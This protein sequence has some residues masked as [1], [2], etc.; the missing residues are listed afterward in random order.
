[1][2]ATLDRMDLDPA[3]DEAA[4]GDDLDAGL[5][6][7]L[8]PGDDGERPVQ[9]LVVA[10]V[11]ALS[12]L[13]G[14]WMVTRAFRGGLV[15]VATGGL[16]VLLGAGLIGLSYRLRRPS[17][18][19]YLVLPAA[20]VVGGAL[21]TASAHG[22]SLPSLVADTVRGG[23][24]SQPPV[25]F[26][27]G[28]MFIAVVLFAFV[29]ASAAALGIAL[30]RPRLAVIA[31]LPV[32]IGGALIQPK[33]SE[34]LASAVAMVLVVASLALAYGVDLARKGVAG[35]GFEA[36]RLMRGA[37]LLALVVGVAFVLAQTNLLF[38]ATDRPQVIPPHKP[39]APPPLTDRVLFTV[40][41]DRPGPW[42][43]GVLDVYQDN[44]FL[45]PS[46]DQS[47]LVK[48]P[49][50]GRVVSTSRPTYTATF[51][52]AELR[53][54]SLPGVS[55]PVAIQTKT[56]HIEYDPRTQV[57]KQA[58]RALTSGSSYTIVAA[59]P[60]GGRELA[61]APPAPPAIA[62][63]F[64]AA[65]PAPAEVTAILSS[66]AGSNGFDRLQA[67]RQ[68]LYGKV[69]AAGAGKPV[70][71]PPQKVVQMLGGGEATP[72]EIVAGEVLLARWAG[73]PARIGYGFYGGQ[74]AAGGAREFH[75]RDGAA[76]LEAYFEGYGWVPIVGTPPKA[77]ASLSNSQKNPD[78]KI[79]PTDELGLVVF[80]P[81][82]GTSIRQLFELVR[83][84][85]SV[86]L[87]IGLLLVLM[88][89]GYPA[90]LKALRSSRRR[91]WARARGAGARIAVAYA[92]FRDRAN[93][94]NIGNPRSSPLRFLAPLADDEEHLELAWLV[95]RSLWGD[96]TRDLRLE[97]VEAAEDMARSVRARMT[98]AQT[99]I[100]RVLAA[101]ARTSLR[102]PWSDEIPNLWATSR[103]S[104][105]VR[106]RRPWPLRPPAGVAVPGAAVLVAVALIAVLTPGRA[107]A[108]TTA[109]FP[110]PLV[111][112]S[113]LGYDVVR[114]AKVE[115]QYRLAGTRR[116]VTEGHVYT[117]RGG[118]A[119]QGSFQVAL[120][121]PD[122]DASRQDIQRA[123]ER[124]LANGFRTDRLGIIRLRTVELTEQRLYLWFPPGHNAMEL[125]VMRK[126]FPD[127]DGVVR[128]MIGVQR[129]FDP[130]TGRTG[131]QP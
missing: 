102:D 99:A 17:T 46:V 77:K 47:R 40:K 92:E 33:G 56:S 70:D 4:P 48:V 12:S 8:T 118:D 24:L 100:N 97:D 64:A 35:G 1:M 62:K 83:Y 73:V 82:Q 106:G 111:R 31:P 2:T 15:P 91:R 29:S 119:V 113:I 45:L 75:P 104:R 121:K 32:V 71:V 38:P 85:V 124:S 28:W 116:M 79:V 101:I 60:P 67:V 44:A 59:V 128:S 52:I 122:V 10:L 66:V 27:P 78:P 76:F 125:W 95:S 18:V 110:D 43:L 105:R 86:V 54:Q 11:A 107:S 6:R 42:H 25:P 68:A 41:S 34:V 22:G 5:G 7:D 61:A 50:S 115:N 131:A 16:G 96:L 20:I 123:V 69:V 14:V 23:G 89:A 37:G 127:A 26:A 49:K 81:V 88:V 103:R 74:A 63:E 36:R 90:L 9:P 114:E 58:D 112:S 3:R 55:D 21:A 120:F 19:Q 98:S 94:L 117:I 72:Y 51:T 65:P 93:D 30:S 84:W 39:P 87:P 13:A 126:S 53:G 130:A 57:F 109:T 129:N 80:V 108:R